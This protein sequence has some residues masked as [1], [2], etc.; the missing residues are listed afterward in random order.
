MIQI[1]GSYM[2]G[3]GS[4]IRIA[5][6]LSVITGKS[7]RVFNIR[8]KRSQAGLKEQHLQ[9]IKALADLCNAKLV[10]VDKGSKEIEFHPGKIDKDRLDIEIGTAGSISL[11]FQTLCIPTSRAENVKIYIQGGGTFGKYA[12]T[13]IYTQKVLLP[14][15]KKFGYKSE[16]NI[17]KH[18]FYPVGGANVNII[19][20]KIDEFKP[21]NLVE[22]GE[23]E[24]IEGISIASLDLKKPKVAERQAQETKEYLKNYKV[25]IKSKYADTNCSGSALILWTKTT[26]DAV[27]GVDVLGEKGK[28]AENVAEE[29]SMNMIRIIKSG[30]AVDRYLGDQLL[31][32]MALAKGKSEITVPEVTNHMRANM[33]VIQKFLDV[34]F[35]INKS[36][37]TKITCSGS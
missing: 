3:G 10:G 12:P 5:T 14:V 4:I 35:E 19:S 15:L 25:E 37:P 22:R 18:G 16:I 32:F 28:K 27:L 33:W 20:Q 30:A 26:T 9:G 7:V 6:A 31:I 2:E 23:I 13:L 1:D 34:K 8:K 29:A 24:K 36:Y 11:I 17:T 21:V